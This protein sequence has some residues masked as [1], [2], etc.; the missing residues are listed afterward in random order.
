MKFSEMIPLEQAYDLL[1]RSRMYYLS[2]FWYPNNA[3]KTGMAI[4]EQKA[5]LFLSQAV[6]DALRGISILDATLK[7]HTDILWCTQVISARNAP[8]VTEAIRT[9]KV[10]REEVDTVLFQWAKI[11]YQ[12]PNSA[13]RKELFDAFDSLALLISQSN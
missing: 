11:G 2:G 1:M 7:S 9:L 13:N 10:L 12:I 4:D 8:E 6:R 3:R 5:I